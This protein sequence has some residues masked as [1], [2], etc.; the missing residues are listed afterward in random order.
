MAGSLMIMSVLGDSWELGVHQKLCV[1][2]MSS[3]HQEFLKMPVN[4]GLSLSSDE[5]AV[6]QRRHEA[7][8]WL[9]T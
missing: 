3:S 7:R 2:I 8:R 5:V 6:G 4:L 9:L 1:L